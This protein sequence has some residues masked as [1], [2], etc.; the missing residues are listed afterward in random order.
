MPTMSSHMYPPPASDIGDP[1][2]PFVWTGMLDYLAS[3]AVP[4]RNL[5]IDSWEESFKIWK[6]SR[7]LFAHV[8]HEGPCH[9]PLPCWLAGTSRASFAADASRRSCKSHASWRPGVAPDFGRGTNIHVDVSKN[10]GIPKWMVYNGTPY[11]LMD[12]LGVPLFLETPMSSC[13]PFGRTWHDETVLWPKVSSNSRGIYPYDQRP[14][15]DLKKNTHIKVMRAT[16]PKTSSSPL[17]I[18][19]APKGRACLPTINFQ[20]LC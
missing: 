18:G 14:L 5:C 16:L 11:F 15:F 13:H 17:K 1:G 3:C 19:R 10:R 4:W 2:D 7:P 12:D 6:M 8:G 20:V 9:E